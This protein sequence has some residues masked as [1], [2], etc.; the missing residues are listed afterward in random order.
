MNK[1]AEQL[2]AEF[3]TFL[4]DRLKQQNAMLF[5]APDYARTF[6]KAQREELDTVRSKFLEL[7]RDE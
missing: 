6:I 4:D 7:L 3:I 5:D 1:T 2:A